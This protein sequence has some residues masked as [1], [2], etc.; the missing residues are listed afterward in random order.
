MLLTLKKE[1]GSLKKVKNKK[2]VLF[3]KTK[4]DWWDILATV[5]GGITA[6][7]I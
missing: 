2:H 5:V 3:T 1:I 6:I 4:F 7:L